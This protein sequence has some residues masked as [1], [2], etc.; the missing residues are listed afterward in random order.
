MS[1]R[2]PPAYRPPPDAHPGIGVQARLGA[3]SPQEVHIHQRSASVESTSSHTSS[4]V[5]RLHMIPM[6]GGVRPLGLQ[7]NNSS[8][9]SLNNSLDGSIGSGWSL[10]KIQRSMEQ[11]ANTFD[12]MLTPLQEGVEATPTPDHMTRVNDT[13]ALMKAVPVK[14]PKPPTLPK[15][16]PAV[17]AKPHQRLPKTTSPPP[18]IVP[19]TTG[20]HGYRSSNHS[21]HDHNSARHSNS[22]RY[23]HNHHHS[24]S[25]SHNSCSSNDEDPASI[26]INKKRPKVP[27]LTTMDPRKPKLKV[28]KVPRSVWQPRPM[29][30]AIQSS[31][32]ESDSDGSD[33]S[34][35]TVVG[36]GDTS[37]L[38]SA[39]V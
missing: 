19:I 9:Q 37:T 28:K 3:T 29:N 23:D 30:G 7:Q 38:R 20:Y 6:D 32:S 17:A 14:A 2:L 25:S 39:H 11:K 18:D 10:D 24:N 27:D 26:A 21:N 5:R 15:P 31:S 35:D 12:N 22:G 13:P 16:P 34:V 4:E 1:G 36:P 8:D 33:Y